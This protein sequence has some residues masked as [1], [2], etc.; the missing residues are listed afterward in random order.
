MSILYQYSIDRLH[1][2]ADGITKDTGH[3]YWNTVVLDTDYSITD[4]LAV[5]Y[6]CLL[7]TGNTWGPI[8]IRSCV[9]IPRQRSRWTTERITGR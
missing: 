1:A 3:M 2:Y 7:L 5:R 8:L 6:R 9:G 4:R